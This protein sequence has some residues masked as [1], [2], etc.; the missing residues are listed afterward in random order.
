[1][2]MWMEGRHAMAVYATAALGLTT[3]CP[4]MNIVL[5]LGPSKGAGN[6]LMISLA[7]M[8]LLVC[9]HVMTWA[10]VPCMTHVDALGRKSI[11]LDS[12]MASVAVLIYAIAV[13]WLRFVYSPTVDVAY[14]SVFGS[15]LVGT[16]TAMTMLMVACIGGSGALVGVVVVV[17]LIGGESWQMRLF[18][19]SVLPGD[20]NQMTKLRTVL[21]IMLVAAVCWSWWSSHAGARPLLGRTVWERR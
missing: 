11:A 16:A 20:I 10:F 8:M 15:L 4:W 21:L 2:S 3:V 14:T 1:M 12:T 17:L 19:F 9:T 13:P 7:D 18:G 5:V 6:H